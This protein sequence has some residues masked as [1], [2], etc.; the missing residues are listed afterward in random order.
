MAKHTRTIRPK[1]IRFCAAV[2]LLLIS[3]V[4]LIVAII[5]GSANCDHGCS[6]EPDSITLSDPV[7][8]AENGQPIDNTQTGT[9]TG[10]DAAI[11]ASPPELPEG[12]TY[13]VTPIEAAKPGNFGFTY[14][15]RR[16]NQEETYSENP[17]ANDYSFG[18]AGSYTSVQGITTFGGNHYRNSF[19]YGTA[20]VAMRSLSQVWSYSVGSLGGFGGVSWTGQPLVVLWEGETLRTLGVREEFR[21]LPSLL[22][23]IY[24]AAD[25]NIYFFDAA[26]GTRTRENI[27]IGSPMFGTPTLDPTGAPMLY[28]GQGTC[29]EGNKSAVY[30]VNLLTNTA[31]TI[32]SGKDYTANRNDWSAF[33]SSPLI[34]SDTLIWPGENGVLYLI[35]L[36]TAYDAQAGTLTIAPGDRIKYRYTGTGY[37]DTSVNGKR[38]YGFESSVSAFGHYLFLCDNGGRLQCIDLNTLKLQ[39]VVDLGDDADAS[40]V[41]EENGN[42]GTFYLYACGQVNTQDP[43]LPTGY[44][45][46]YVQ[47]IDGLTGSVV[48]KKEQ[49]AITVDNTKGGVRATPH[50][51]RG[52]I[53]DLLIC[54]YYGL[55]VDVMDEQGNVTFEY[56]GK[57]VAYDRSN[58]AVR[59]EIKQTGNADYVSSPLVVY[60]ERGDAYLIAC[61]RSGAVKLYDA[62]DPGENALYTMELGARI[63]AT[64]VAVGNYVYVATTGTTTQTR[65]YCLKLE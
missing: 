43:N 60:T 22:E 37:A 50:I 62:S 32:I 18:K 41:I 53:G 49:I 31:Q 5:F 11:I 23:V 56:G 35:K 14:E 24:C 27:A 15:I 19:S 9:Q 51:G 38:W 42:D 12:M 58:G 57:I 7:L 33:D 39:Y 47:K 44:G 28:I 10:T 64:P 34:I 55:A 59:W 21:V 29:T 17:L 4:L 25:G 61:D 45:Y 2:F 8:D 54:S 26:T 40:I 30:A 13:S 65:I 16:N 3:I 46:S 48:W 36:N 1:F 52:T 20:T 6:R 63:D